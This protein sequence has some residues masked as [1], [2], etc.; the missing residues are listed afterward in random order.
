MLEYERIL[1]YI[2]LNVNINICWQNRIHEYTSLTLFLTLFYDTRITKIS[3]AISYLNCIQCKRWVPTSRMIQNT[4]NWNCMN[5]QI[6]HT[7][8]QRHK[9]FYRIKIICATTKQHYQSQ[10]AVTQTTPK[11]TRCAESVRNT[12]EQNRYVWNAEK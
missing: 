8:T 9:W 3:R 11:S 1:E 10:T 5:N 7:T 6:C 12:V 4:K 2:I